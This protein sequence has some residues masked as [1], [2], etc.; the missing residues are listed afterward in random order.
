MEEALDPRRPAPATGETR[1]RLRVLTLE[2]LIGRRTADRLHTLV[3]EGAAGFGFEGLEASAAPFLC[4][5]LAELRSRHADLIPDTYQGTELP[6]RSLV[7]PDNRRAV[8]FAAR[9]R[10]MGDA[11]DEKLI[12]LRNLLHLREQYPDAF[13][14]GYR[15]IASDPD[16]LAFSR[17]ARAKRLVMVT[18]LRSKAGCPRDWVHGMER[19]EMRNLLGAELPCA[20]FVT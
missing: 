16:C 10:I 18:A 5:L 9:E 1:A 2:H 12:L 6:D 20:V 7:D 3:D 4:K 19:D 15:R 14:G 11:G 17:G 13:E 8:D